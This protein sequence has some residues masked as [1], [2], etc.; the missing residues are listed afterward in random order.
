MEWILCW[1][2]TWRK[3]W[4]LHDKLRTPILTNVSRFGPDIFVTP[5]GVKMPKHISS[6]RLVWPC[7]PPI[8]GSGVDGEGQL[9]KS[10]ARRTDQT[11]LMQF[12]GRRLHRVEPLG[13]Q[14]TKDQSANHRHYSTQATHTH[15]CKLLFLPCTCTCTTLLGLTSTSLPLTRPLAAEED[16]R[17]PHICI[18]AATEHACMHHETNPIYIHTQAC[19]QNHC[20]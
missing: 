15:I 11:Q 16:T 10:S 19:N 6:R 5:F 20:T 14:A 12:C 13:W 17:P 1:Q 8:F 3:A 4:N 9:R 18:I 2:T 7:S